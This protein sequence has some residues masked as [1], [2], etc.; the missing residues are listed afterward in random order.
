MKDTVVRELTAVEALNLQVLLKDKE[1][2]QARID[3]FL[4]QIGVRTGEVVQ[5]RVGVPWTIVR[6]VADAAQVA[7][8]TSEADGIGRQP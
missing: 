4:A 7:L 2:A 1:L 5:G 3:V 6:Q 8:P